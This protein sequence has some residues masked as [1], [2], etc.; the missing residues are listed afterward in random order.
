LQDTVFVLDIGTRSVLALLASLQEEEL[1]V[2][3][4]ISREHQTRAML[5]G[6]IHHVEEV[7]RIVEELVQE[8]QQ[9]TGR[10]LKKVAVAAAGRTL[11][12]VKGSA[13]IVHP[14]STVFTKE[15]VLSLELQAVQEAQLALPKNQENVPLSLQYYC[16]G[17]SIAEERLDNVKI[18]SLV[19]QRGEEAQ[20][21]IIATFLPRMVVDSLQIVVESVGLEIASITLEPI[22]VA[23]LVLNPA[24]RRLNLVLVDIGAGTSDIAVC[25]GNFISA[26][27]MVPMAGDEITEA[28]SEQY[29]LD[30]NRAEEVKRQL[31]SKQEISAVSILG[32]EEVYMAEEIRQ[33]LQPGIVTLASAI[34]ETIL[35]LNNKPP[36]ALLLVGGGSLTS[37]LDKKLAE[38][39][40]LSEDRV[41]VQ[42]ANKIQRVHNLP[43]EFSGPNFIT[44]LAIAYT[45][46]T[47]STMSFITVYINDQP[48]RMLNLAQNNVAGALLA[49]GYN[50]KDVYARPGMALTCEINGKIYSIPGEEG[51][52]GKILLNERL[53]EFSEEIK[54]EDNI[55]FI[56]GQKGQ[57]AVITFGELLKDQIG[58]CYVNGQEV[59]LLPVIKVEDKI[60]STQDF[61]VDG[62]K[63]EIESSYT[64]E[65]VLQKADLIT[66]ENMIIINGRKVNLLEI[67]EIT[68]NG[69]KASYKER[70]FPG[71]DLTY[72]ELSE[73]YIKDIIVDEPLIHIEVMV[74]D[75][76]V[77]LDSLRV[78]LNKTKINPREAISLQDGDVL[79]YQTEGSLYKPILV[80]IFNEIDF[81]TE[82]PPGK[83][84][85]VILLNGVEREYT[86]PLQQGDRIQIRWE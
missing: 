76:P 42:Q 68:K 49:G 78:W 10:E 5:D 34:A 53:V 30:F 75:C 83:S 33:N 21:E 66:G 54:H 37:G 35:E 43:E 70:V 16:V 20:I 40:N 23:N 26:F 74:N 31:N 64:I 56:P 36:Q 60:M 46:L 77:K 27:G 69:E 4:L 86:Y 72:A 22:A 41:A 73:L 18:G 59:E 52:P 50:L 17:Y 11:E 1:V 81:S 85:L 47:N 79:E 65:E 7:V 19:G 80:D 39:L 51:K 58:I 71:D 13:K 3:H 82:P 8:M 63:A 61:V 55:R 44:V 67:A 45:A 15:E 28:I 9:V 2:E 48:V 24:M 12:T 25:G 62:C 29:L 14:V 6:Q 84:K 57:D 38:A 32:K